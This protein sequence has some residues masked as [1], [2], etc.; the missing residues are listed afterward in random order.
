[1]IPSNRIGWDPHRCA[2]S[3]RLLRTLVV[4]TVE[5][6]SDKDWSFVRDEVVKLLEDSECNRSGGELH[7]FS[8]TN[9][10]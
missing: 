10:S 5:E 7:L 4:I 1:M 9:V 6:E 3:M 8:A 2:G